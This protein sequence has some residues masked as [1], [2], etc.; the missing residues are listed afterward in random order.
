MSLLFT[1]YNVVAFNHQ[2]T[3]IPVMTF[4][5]QRKKLRV[6]RNGYEL[7]KD[8]MLVTYSAEKKIQ[9]VDKLKNMIKKSGKK[10]AIALVW[11]PTC[12]YCPKQIK[13][14]YL[15]SKRHPQVKTFIIG[16]GKSIEDAY[17]KYKKSVG[18]KAL[19]DFLYDQDL[20]VV[21]EFFRNMNSTP[22]PFY[23]MFSKEGRV[24][25][26]VA[27]TLSWDDIGSGIVKTKFEE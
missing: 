6:I 1:F 11:T 15:F 17:E 21:N 20:T 3:N 2:Y 18:D 19:G 12:A 14:F 4:L 8:P 5:E 26:R 13:D 27:G 7:N 16:A 9:P 24:I 22:V 25:G 23:V 10:G